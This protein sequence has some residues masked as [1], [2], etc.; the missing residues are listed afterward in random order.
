MPKPARLTSE[1]APPQ[2]SFLSPFPGGWVQA[3][4]LGLLHSCIC[5]E[6]HTIFKI[7]YRILGQSVLLLHIA[8]MAYLHGDITKDMLPRVKSLQKVNLLPRFTWEAT[9]S[10]PL[11]V[12][13][14]LQIPL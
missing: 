7:F 2:H 10:L 6:F 1:V 9:I 8:G 11:P 13:E 14:E 12:E 3:E 5:L 4:A